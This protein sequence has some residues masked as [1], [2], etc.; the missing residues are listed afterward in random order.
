MPAGQGTRAV[1]GA[2]DIFAAAVLTARDPDFQWR[3]LATCDGGDDDAERRLAS[4]RAYYWEG[5]E[6]A[7]DTFKG[8]NDINEGTECH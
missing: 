5:F 1:L 4:Y 3:A 7:G 2:L 6:G 8:T